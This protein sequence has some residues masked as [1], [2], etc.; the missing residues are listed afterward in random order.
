[1]VRYCTKCGKPENDDSV[2]NCAACG[3]KLLNLDPDQP[4]KKNKS[5]TISRNELFDRAI[6]FF[7]A[8]KYSVIAQTDY[9]ISFES[10][11][12]DV[13]WVI[14]VVLCCIGLI[15]A[16]IYYFWFTHQHQVTLTIS[17]TDQVSVNAIGNTSKA[18]KDAAE[19]MLSF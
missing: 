5:K 7:S 3:T 10:Q 9:V 14:M 16:A 13:S 4:F 18:K 2:E 12:R 6:P 11:D 17:G 19:F 15:P 8:K 1:M